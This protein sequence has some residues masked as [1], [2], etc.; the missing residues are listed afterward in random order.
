M[1]K[2]TRL[3]SSGLCISVFQDKPNKLV[4]MAD[5]DGRINRKP[6]G[7]IFNHTAE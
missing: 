5:P 7:Q 1:L 4:H 2:Q 3:K 6:K